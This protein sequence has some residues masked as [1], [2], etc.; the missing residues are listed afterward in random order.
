MKPEKP[1]VLVVLDGWGLRSEREFNAP[2]VGKTPTIDRLFRQYPHSTLKASGPSVGLPK[3][4]FG[5][6]EAG[7]TTI[8][9]GRILDSDFVRIS[10]SIKD[11]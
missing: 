2:K 6:S 1:H 9:S 4:Q 11:V 10:K 5:N 7:H 3:G 8:G